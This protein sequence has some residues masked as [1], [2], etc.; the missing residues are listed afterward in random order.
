MKVAGHQSVNFEGSFYDRFF[1][2][3]PNKDIGNQKAFNKFGHALASPHWNRLAIGFAACTQPIIDYFNPKVDRDTAKASSYRSMAKVISCT[4]VGFIVR[5]ASYKLIEK[6]AHASEAEGSTLLTPKAILAEKN[7]ELRKSKLKIHKN[8][9]STVFAL[10]VMIFTNVLLDAPLT[11]MLANK[12]IS[13]DKQLNR[14]KFDG[15]TV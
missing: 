4:G 11:S 2:S 1:K 5:G 3:I 15:G 9:Y 8:A 14:K 6:F 7:P 10:F 13:S 12:F